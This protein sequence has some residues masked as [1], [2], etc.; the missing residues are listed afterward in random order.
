MKMRTPADGS[1]AN[2]VCG[3]ADP[4]PPCTTTGQ[5]SSS[6][7]APGVRVPP[8][9]P[10]VGYAPFL[11]VLSGALTATTSAA[12]GLQASHGP[13]ATGK[14]GPAIFPERFDGWPS[15]PAA[16]VHRFPRPLQASN[17]FQ[18]S[19]G[20]G[21]GFATSSA[22]GSRA[23]FVCDHR[24]SGTRARAGYVRRTRISSHLVIQERH[25]VVD[26]YMIYATMGIIRAERPS[27][28]G[29]DRYTWQTGG[30]AS[31]PDLL[32]LEAMTAV[33]SKRVS[34]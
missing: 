24:G 18:R 26:L 33:P 19:R 31:P 4:V 25:I 10:L 11:G 29:L 15:N 27:R 7:G 32:R 14:P 16:W 2:M 34:A 6:Q 28:Y 12:Q 17:G 21:C 9:V 13:L 3:S 8:P 5:Y 22:A 23:A 1:G 30:V 20:S